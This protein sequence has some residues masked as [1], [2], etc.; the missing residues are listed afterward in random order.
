MKNSTKIMVL[1]EIILLGLIFHSLLEMTPLFFGANI[2]EPGSTGNMPAAMTWFCLCFYLIPM[3]SIVAVLYLSCRWVK[4]TNFVVSI[5]FLL[6]D[7]VHFITDGIIGRN[8]VQCILLLF[9]L[10][11]SVLL[12]IASLGWMREKQT[13]KVYI[14]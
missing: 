6:M 10:L 8:P 5:L 13:K 1:W 12:F 9:I 3:L 4:I 14:Q 11:V 2:A 7:A